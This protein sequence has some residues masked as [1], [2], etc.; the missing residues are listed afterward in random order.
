[1]DRLERFKF[2]PNRGHIYYL[3]RSQPPLFVHMLDRYINATND[4]SIL[5]R[6]VPLAELELE[7]W[8]TNRSISVTS[9][10]TSQTYNMFHYAVNSSASRPES[11]W[12]DYQTATGVNMTEE[13]RSDLYAELAT[14]AES[15]WKA[16]ATSGR[17]QLDRSRFEVQDAQHQEHHPRRL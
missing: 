3:N 6:A 4:T 7:W 1:M 14:G 2:I 10:Y 17:K 12:E 8:P 15:G 5:E 9:S 16:Q 11:H 13:Q